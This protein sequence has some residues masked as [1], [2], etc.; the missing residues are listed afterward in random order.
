[1]SATLAFNGLKGNRSKIRDHEKLEILL[2]DL[3]RMK[4]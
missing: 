1:M 2:S 3:Y 4:Q